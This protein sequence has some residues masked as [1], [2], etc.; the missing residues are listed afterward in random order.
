M[1]EHLEETTSSSHVY[2]ALDRAFWCV[3][4]QHHNQQWITGCRPHIFLSSNVR[5]RHID[6]NRHLD[7]RRAHRARNISWTPQNLKWS[8]FRTTNNATCCLIQGQRAF[9]RADF[10]ARTMHPLT[11]LGHPAP[12][13]PTWT[14]IQYALSTCNKARHAP[15]VHRGA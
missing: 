2:Q 4:A 6:V 10:H 5:A 8:N 3:V 11:H 7:I 9:E 13:Q 15:H 12:V 1:S 14:D